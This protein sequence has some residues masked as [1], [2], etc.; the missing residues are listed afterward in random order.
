MLGFTVGADFKLATYDETITA[1]EK[2]TT[3]KNVRLLNHAWD[4]PAALTT[5]GAISEEE[6]FEISGGKLRMEVPVRLNRLVLEYDHLLICGPVFPHEVVGFSGG[7]KYFF[8]GIAGADIINLSFEFG[9][10]VTRSEIPDILSA[11][12]YA[13][14]KGTLVVGASGNAAARSIAAIRR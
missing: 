4:D 2:A 5:L 11:L 3:Y 8:P 1:E 9:T 10:Q 6:V 14:R 12:R 7:N 13:R